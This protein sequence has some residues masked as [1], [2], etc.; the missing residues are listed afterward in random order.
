MKKTS[1][2]QPVVKNPIIKTV[3]ERPDRYTAILTGTYAD[4]STFTVTQKAKKYLVLTQNRQGQ[5]SPILTFWVN[6]LDNEDEHAKALEAQEMADAYTAQTCQR[7]LV[8]SEQFDGSGRYIFDKSIKVIR[9][10]QERAE[11]EDNTR[12]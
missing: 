8:A 10:M 9:A 5:Y 11:K 6:P 1:K 3:I 2:R 7:T 4:G 12:F